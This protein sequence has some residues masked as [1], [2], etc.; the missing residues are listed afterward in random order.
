MTSKAEVRVMQ[1]Q[2]KE[3]QELP[4]IQ[5]QKDSPLEPLETASP[6]QHL[7]LSSDFW[8]YK[9]W[10]R[11]NFCCFMPPSLQKFIPAATEHGHIHQ[12]PS[13]LGYTCQRP[14]MC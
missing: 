4:G 12:L 14:H 8:P 7:D 1:P 10:E 11:R 9:S 5:S 6:Y 2:A 13:L 3:Y